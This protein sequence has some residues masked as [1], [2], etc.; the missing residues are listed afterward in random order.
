MYTHISSLIGCIY[1]NARTKA[2]NCE[3]HL[4]SDFSQII[5]AIIFFSFNADTHQQHET[6]RT[7]YIYSDKVYIMRLSIKIRHQRNK[8][9]REYIF[10][11]HMGIRA[12]SSSVKPHFIQHRWRH[13]IIIIM[14]LRATSIVFVFHIANNCSC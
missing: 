13:S 9:V 10:E 12:S 4:V 3:R 8:N 7:D 6:N 14:Q 11:N 5:N 2:I 1:Q